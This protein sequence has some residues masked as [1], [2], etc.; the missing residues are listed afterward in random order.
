MAWMLAFCGHTWWRKVENP[1]KTTDFG[2][3]ITS[4]PHADTGIR[5]W[6][7]AVASEY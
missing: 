4:L 2:R 3:A 1:R 6:V 7:A 5:F